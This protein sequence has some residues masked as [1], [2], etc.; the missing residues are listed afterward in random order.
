MNAPSDVRTQIMR[1]ESLRLR[2]YVDTVGKSTIGY[3]RDLIDKGISEYEALVL[4][5]NDISECTGTLKARLPWFNMLDEPRQAVLIGMCFNLGFNG[6]E[7]FTKMLAAAAHG[8]YIEAS[9]EMLAS[10]WAKQVGDRAVR[11]AKQ[12]ITGAWV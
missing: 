8:D 4:L 1:D 9:E 12:M 2:P 11:L 5:D 10:E 6:L 3:G 7:E